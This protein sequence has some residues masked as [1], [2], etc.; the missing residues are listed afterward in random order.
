MLV[1]LSCACAK[2]VAF[3]KSVEILTYIAIISKY[4]VSLAFIAELLFSLL[5]G[6]EKKG[7]GLVQIPR[8]SLHNP[9]NWVVLR[10]R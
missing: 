10:W 7:P 6:R 8:L 5:L 4:N 1:L 2:K 3:S 9:T